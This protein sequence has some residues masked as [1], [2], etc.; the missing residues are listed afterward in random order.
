LEGFVDQLAAAEGQEAV[1]AVLESAANSNLSYR[2]L[3]RFT[4]LGL[5]VLDRLES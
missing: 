5:S 4:T 3:G 2:H 1:I